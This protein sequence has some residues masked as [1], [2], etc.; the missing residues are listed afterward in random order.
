MK[1]Q[2]I[3]PGGEPEM[4][5]KVDKYLNLDENVT[6]IKE[7]VRLIQGLVDGYPGDSSEGKE[8]IEQKISNEVTW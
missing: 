8:L 6:K 2:S 5:E 4:M 1:F 7:A 3:G